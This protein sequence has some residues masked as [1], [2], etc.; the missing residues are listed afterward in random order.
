M[1]LFNQHAQHIVVYTMYYIQD[2]LQHATLPHY[3]SDINICHTACC[4]RT[5]FK[6]KGPLWQYHV[7]GKVHAVYI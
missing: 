5:C 4:V 1:A 7:Q 3:V 2:I 6:K